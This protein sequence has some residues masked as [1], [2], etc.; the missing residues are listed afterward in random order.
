MR[1]EESNKFWIDPQNTGGSHLTLLHTLKGHKGTIFGVA[2]S[3]DGQVLASGSEDKI[4]RLWDGPTG[5]LLQTL[6]G[7]TN[8]VNCISQVM[9]VFSPQI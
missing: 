3:P 9:V 8:D 6:E 4:V 2:W 5:K 7:H 1:E